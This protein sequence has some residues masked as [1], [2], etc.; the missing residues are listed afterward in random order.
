MYTS[1][2]TGERI[3]P[4]RAARAA[5][6]RYASPSWAYSARMNAVRSG[7]SAGTA[8]RN[9]VLSPS[10]ARGARRPGSGRGR[11]DRAAAARCAA[12]AGVACLGMFV[13][14]RLA[15]I[16]VVVGQLLARR[17]VAQGVDER[18]AGLDDDLAVRIAGVV[19][20]ARLVAADR[21]VDDPAAIHRQ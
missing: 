20:E 12:M 14:P 7:R 4:S 5:A 8:R 6:G 21:G 13:V 11:E 10:A 9:R 15:F 16:G 19:D 18:P 2:R 17:D 3:R 1:P